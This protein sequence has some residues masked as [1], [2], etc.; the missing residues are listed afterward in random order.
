MDACVLQVAWPR[1]RSQGPWA[2]GPRASTSRTPK[3][4]GERDTWAPLTWGLFLLTEHA[5]QALPWSGDW[6]QLGCTGWDAWSRVSPA[7]GPAL[8]AGSLGVADQST[9]TS[10]G[11][12]NSWSCAPAPASSTSWDCPTGSDGTKHWSKGLGPEWGTDST[13]S[14]G[15]PGASNYPTSWDSGLH[16]DCT[17]SSKEH[18]SSDLTSASEPKQQ[19]DRATLARYRRTNHRGERSARLG[20]EGAMTESI[21]AGPRRLRGWGPGNWW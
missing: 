14:W 9:T 20:P 5:S 13:I 10:A 18:Q 16:T 2:P 4:A 12:T 1:S 7:P 17:S 6:T 8:F 21:E 19:S 3:G 11:E 15:G